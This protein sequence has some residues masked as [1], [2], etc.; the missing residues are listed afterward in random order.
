MARAQ[1]GRRT[2]ASAEH[3][4]ARGKVHRAGWC[5]V[6]AQS[7]CVQYHSQVEYSGL[8]KRASER[9]PSYIKKNDAAIDS[10]LAK[11]LTLAL[12]A[13]DLLVR[14]RQPHSLHCPTLSTPIPSRQTQC[15]GE[16][17]Y[18]QSCV[19]SLKKQRGI[20]TAT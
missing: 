10:D 14:V 4:A 17:V 8:L 7:A 15:C 19:A 3:G 20:G 1:R 2:L 13:S 12:A 6:Y 9:S 18:T 5:L 16:H 11:A